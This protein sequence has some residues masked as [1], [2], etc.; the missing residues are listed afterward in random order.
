MWLLSIT[1]LL[2]TY[3]CITCIKVTTSVYKL[4]GI[5]HQLVNRLNNALQNVNKS[6]SLKL[7]P[8]ARMQIHQSKEYLLGH[9]KSQTV[10]PSK[11]AQTSNNPL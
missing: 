7:I 6:S 5:C 1:P 4:L 9:I 10:R 2:T 8:Q 11:A 3:I